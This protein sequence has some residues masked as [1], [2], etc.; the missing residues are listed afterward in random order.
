MSAIAQSGEM[1]LT[2]LRDT[3]LKRGE[4][5]TCLDCHRVQSCGKVQLISGGAKLNCAQAGSF[6]FWKDMNPPNGGKAKRGK[7][8]CASESRRKTEA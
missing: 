6:M 7:G 5:V 2:K 8:V 4:F 3:K 1:D